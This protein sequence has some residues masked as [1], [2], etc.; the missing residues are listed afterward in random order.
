MNDDQKVIGGSVFSKLM[1]MSSAALP[2][3]VKAV[4]SRLLTAPRGR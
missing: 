2:D 3:S 1:G 4:G